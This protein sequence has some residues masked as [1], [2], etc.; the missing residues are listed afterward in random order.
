MHSKSLQILVTLRR[1]KPSF[2][3]NNQLK[4]ASTICSY[5][6]VSSSL[7]LVSYLVAARLLH[8]TFLVD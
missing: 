8:H 3:F 4:G 2:P 1:S 7:S 5:S 6:P